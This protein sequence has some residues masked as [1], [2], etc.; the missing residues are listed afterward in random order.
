M[1]RVPFFYYSVVIRRP[2]NK[3]GKRVLLGN[4]DKRDPSSSTGSEDELV[5]ILAIPKERPFFAG[6]L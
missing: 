3:Q 4:L 6:S 2:P 5:L 1:I